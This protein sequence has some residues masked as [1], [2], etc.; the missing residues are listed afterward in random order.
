MTKIVLAV[1]VALLAERTLLI[2]ENPGSNQAIVNFYKEQLPGKGHLKIL[3]R[4]IDANY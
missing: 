4:R 1:V 3:K 2:P